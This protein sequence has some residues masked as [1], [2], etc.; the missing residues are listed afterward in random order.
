LI[1]GTVDRF[2]TV[3]TPNVANNGLDQLSVKN[4][5]EFPN[6][7]VLSIDANRL[8]SLPGLSS[9]TSLLRLT[10]EDNSIAAL[11]EGLVELK[12]I[13]HVDFTGNDLSK[14]DE[15]IG[16][17][18]NLVTF[19]IAHNPLRERKFLSNKPLDHKR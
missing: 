2:S 11:P 16:R 1:P 18:D 15:R 12:S 13:R 17:M 8:R 4:T 14:L 3:Q 10:A 19:R 5:I 6:L 7:Q 9:W